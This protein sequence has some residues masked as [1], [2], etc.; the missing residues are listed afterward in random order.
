MKELYLFREKIKD[1]NLEVFNEC[2]DLLDKLC[3][4]I[5]KGDDARGNLWDLLMD[6]IK[7]KLRSENLDADQAQR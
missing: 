7:G 3:E 1:L 6:A 5:L 4:A 2:G